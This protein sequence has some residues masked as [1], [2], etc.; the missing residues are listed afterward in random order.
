MVDLPSKKRLGLCARCHE[1]YVK[2]WPVVTTLK[3]EQLVS[4]GE[5][6]PDCR[7]QQP[8]TLTTDTWAY[9]RKGVGYRLVT[10]C[11]LRE[12]SDG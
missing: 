8:E 7:P 6:C 9:T 12:A 3:A 5:W 2:W 11:A 4:E 1:P 10:G